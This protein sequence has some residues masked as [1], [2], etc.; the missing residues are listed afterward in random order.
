MC[1]LDRRSSFVDD[2][3]AI[4]MFIS[5]ARFALALQTVLPVPSTCQNS[6]GSGS[7]LEPDE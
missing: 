3:I 5:F 4:C 6:P 2:L 1:M 7:C